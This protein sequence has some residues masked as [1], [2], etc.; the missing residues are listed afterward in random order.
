MEM[1]MTKG[2]RVYSKGFGWHGETT[3]EPVTIVRREHDVT[4]IP[5]GEWYVIRFDDGAQLC[6][7]VSRLTAGNY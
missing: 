6:A 5:D 1:T 2:Q 4:S 3:L 7:H